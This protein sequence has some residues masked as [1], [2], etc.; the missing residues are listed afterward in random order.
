MVCPLLERSRSLRL[1]AVSQS[2]IVLL[3]KVPVASRRAVRTEDQSR[4]AEEIVVAGLQNE[5][6]FGFSCLLIG[7][8]G[9]C[10]TTAL[11]AETAFVRWGRTW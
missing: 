5:F 2:L 10:W 8:G 3:R 7:C 9:C 11:N 4:C 1:V 6:G